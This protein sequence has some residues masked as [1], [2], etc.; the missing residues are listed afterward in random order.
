MIQGA[1][2][3]DAVP[4][5]AVDTNP[6]KE[7][8]ARQFGATHFINAAEVDTLEAIKEICPN[9]VDVSFEC[10]GHPALIRTVDR[11][12]RLGRHRA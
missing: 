5:I 8:L 11:R 7:E 12:P 3:A 2:L 4:I 10:V 9:G 6:R 1:A